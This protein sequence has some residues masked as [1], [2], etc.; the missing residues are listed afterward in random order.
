[1]NQTLKIQI[2]KLILETKLPWTKCLPLALFRIRTAP[3]KHVGLSPYE[4]LY[5]FPNLGRIAELPTM[6]TKDNF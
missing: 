2:S 3:R 5:G 6:E 4:I 1:M